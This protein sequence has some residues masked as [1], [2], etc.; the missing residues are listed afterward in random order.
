MMFIE[1][2]PRMLMR[3]EVS[4]HIECVVALHRVDM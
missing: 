3:S 2:C 4:P 1:S